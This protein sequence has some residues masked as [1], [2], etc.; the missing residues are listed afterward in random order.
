MKNVGAKIKTAF[1]CAV[2]TYSFSVKGQIF[3]WAKNFGGNTNDAGLAVTSDASGN[4]YST[5]FFQGTADFDPGPGTFTLSSGGGTDI[6]ISKLDASGNFLWARSIGAAGSDAGQGIKTDGS[7]NVYVTGRFQGTVDFDPGAGVSNLTS[8]G[9]NDIFVLK[10]TGS[11]NF[12]WAR[13]MGGT[14]DDQGTS[15]VIDGSGNVYSTGYFVGTGD[16]DP[17]VAT[18]TMTSIG[19]NNNEDAYVSK[20]DAS[21]NFVWA[22]QFIAVS[23]APQVFGNSIDIDAA[24]NLLIGGSFTGQVDFDPGA[25]TFSLTAIN[26]D[27]YVCKLT[28]SA[29]L[30]WV[31]RA[32]GTNGSYTA[33]GVTS[34][35]SNNVYATGY[36]DNTGDFDPGVG[37]YSLTS[38]GGVDAYVLKLDASG[39]FQ[40]A[41]KFGSTQGDQGKGITVSASG[42]VYTTG[43]FHN[44]ADF[45][46]GVGTYTLGNIGG[47]SIY[48]SKLN[49]SGSFVWAYAFGYSNSQGNGISINPW[50]ELYTTGTFDQITDFDPGP[51]AYSLTPTGGGGSADVFVH[52]MGQSICPT[53]SINSVVNGFTL[54]CAITSL[55]LNAVN[56]STLAGVTFT[57]TDPSLNNFPGS[58]YTATAAGVY[59][60]SSSA[61]SNTCIVTQT[62]SVF[63]TT[64]NVNY[65]VAVSNATCNADGSA[66]VNPISGTPP[67][68]YTWSVGGN[69]NNVSGLAQGVYSV[70]VMDANQCVL[71]KTFSVG[72]AASPFAS[73]PIC[74]VSVDSLSQYNVITWDKTQF[75]GADSFIVYREITT[76]NYQPI[77]SQPYSSFSQFADTVRT[78]YFPNT[79]D[80]N[81]GTY[82]YK[83]KTRDTCGNYSS[84]SPYHNTIFIT[85]NNGTFSWPQLYVIEGQPN[86]V[87]AYILER[88]NYSNGNWGAIGSVSGTQQFIIDPNYNSWVGIA[89]WRVR[90]QWN[91]VCTPTMRA[92]T[93]ST[94][95][96]NKIKTIATGIKKQL[97]NDR[98]KAYPNPAKDRI[99]ISAAGTEMKNA[100]IEL[101]QINGSCVY[102]ENH[103]LSKPLQIDLSQ[104]TGGVY[105]IRIISEKQTVTGR[106]IIEK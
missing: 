95:Y 24:G 26:M 78:L 85:N 34:D 67:Y 38:S 32:G 56:T 102:N 80:P 44:G 92:V 62:L 100:R 36:F 84:F 101:L 52:K 40:W 87:V 6:Y 45:D 90:T 5:G 35:G 72:S 73:V 42:D 9:N 4:V 64:G 89:S 63:Q 47:T 104:Y 30:V 59:T 106:V 22:V 28:P 77:Q 41:G 57:W 94:S 66:T 7:G 99:T 43:L 69:T 86:P 29:G 2:I 105:L 48:I 65:S 15:I 13:G 49:S 61:P 58:A 25:G 31:K 18:F 82:R 17:G 97:S 55:T 75:A 79:G 46:P 76:N 20:L 91:I 74:F 27:A 83:M 68:T 98:L 21:G 54:M 60:I 23:G 37:T 14:S 103:D 33:F 11:G 8:A 96:S 81:I 10:L 3:Q 39:N 12:V 88:D 53:F 70:T 19:G 93:G 51:G 1:L 50:Y 71:T 16:F